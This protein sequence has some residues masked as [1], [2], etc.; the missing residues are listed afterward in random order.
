MNGYTL[1]NHFRKLRASFT[2]SAIEADLFY[3]L[4]ALCNERNWPTE[5][6]YP[7]HLLC[8]TLS[9][10]AESTLIRARNRLKQAGLLEFTSGHK[11]SPTVY[12]FID[13]DAPQ[14]PLHSAS[15]NAS[16]S[17][18]ISAS[19]SD[20]CI[21]KE[22]TKRKTKPPAAAGE[23]EVDL[24]ESSFIPSPSA[25]LPAWQS[26]LLA[27]APE[28][29]RLKTPLT[30]EQWASLVADFGEPLVQE[31]LL[32]MQNHVGLTRKY[33]SANLTARDW[34]KRRKPAEQVA[35][36]PAETCS[37]Q[38]AA[39]GLAQARNSPEYQRYLAELAQEPEAT[40]P[41]AVDAELQHAA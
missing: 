25:D 32:A 11:R 31:V 3:E 16:R 21:Y 33:T 2:F 8:A 12:R 30:A 37:T 39:D 18:S 17:E 10:L 9:N 35:T 34:C 23:G 20:S 5:F 41:Q 38:S 7:N 19:R 29:Q 24:A 15:R 40:S 26:W 28:V 22:K 27:N 14:I 36:R 4:V 6:Q 1:A 13:P